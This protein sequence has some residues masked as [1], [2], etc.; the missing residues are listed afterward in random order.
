MGALVIPLKPPVAR[1]LM[2]DHFA[3]LCIQRSMAINFD[4]NKNKLEKAT[5]NSSTWLSINNY[6]IVIDTV[7]S[8]G[9]N[10]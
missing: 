9:S 7:I 1:S 4:K 3:T 5:G 2:S 6:K 10:M 8:F